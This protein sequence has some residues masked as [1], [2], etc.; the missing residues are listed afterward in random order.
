MRP[1]LTVV[2][3]TTTLVVLSQLS[4]TFVNAQCTHGEVR[5]VSTRSLTTKLFIP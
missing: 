5:V 4:G 3:T 1:L 2:S